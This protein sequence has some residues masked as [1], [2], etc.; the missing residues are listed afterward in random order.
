MI[1]PKKHMV[2]GW[3]QGEVTSYG[4]LGALQQLVTSKRI[5]LDTSLAP[6]AVRLGQKLGYLG[7]L[8]HWSCFEGPK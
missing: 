4:L 7:T 5:E 6:L 3:L 2:P 1:G 8:G